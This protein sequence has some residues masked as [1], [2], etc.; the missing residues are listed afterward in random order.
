M[1]DCG[2]VQKVFVPTSADDKKHLSQIQGVEITDTAAEKILFFCKT[3]KK[4][5]TEYGLRVGV[6][7]DGCS[8]NSYTMELESIA[9]SKEKGDKI[10]TYKG[11]TVMVEKLSYLFVV[12]SRVDYQET[13]LASGFQLVNPN[14]K[15]SCSC[16]SSFAV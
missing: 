3:D 13:L 15:K 16:G 10:F 7:K 4:D 9:E 5:S 11:A 2:N 12:G 6:V 14:V 8:G 1:S